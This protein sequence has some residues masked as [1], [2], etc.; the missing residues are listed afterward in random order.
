MPEGGKTDMLTY[1]M[2]KYI[3]SDYIC[4]EVNMKRIFTV[5]I[6]GDT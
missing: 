3:C 4:E 5:H 2:Q 6:F 1:N